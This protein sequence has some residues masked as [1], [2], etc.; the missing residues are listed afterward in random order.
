MTERCL[1]R[2][3]A[4]AT[5]L[6]LALLA[7]ACASATQPL[8][9]PSSAVS[10]ARVLIAPAGGSRGAQPQ[11]GIRVKVVDGT[12][13]GV[14]VLTSGDPVRGKLSR[15]G[16]TWR[17][18]WALDTAA[19]YTVVVKARDSAGRT[20]TQKSSFRTL[21][22][23][24]T[25]AAR[26]FE[27]EG[28]TYGVGMPIILDFSRP[29]ADRRVVERSLELRTSK[30][31]VGAWYWDGESTLSFRPRD[32]WPPGTRVSFVGHLDGVEGAPGV[33]GV[34]TLRQ[35]FV[36]G[37]SLIVVANTATHRVHVYRDKRL[38]G[39][40]PMS[41]GRPGDDTPNG[42]YLTIE[43]ANPQEMKGPGYDIM[44]PWSVRFTW[45]GDFLHDAS[46]SV[47]QQGYANV[48]HGCVN[49]SPEHAR[50]FYQLAVPGI[51]VTIAGSPRGGR[52]DNGWTLWFLSWRR[53]LQGSALHK[54]VRANA[55]GSRFVD[56]SSLRASRAKAPLARPGDGNAA[57]G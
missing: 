42:T 44:V 47:G 12:I 54:A 46:W 36:I 5:A 11:D 4:S 38:F 43:K 1:R 30:P 8:P 39:D 14:S 56:P 40:W 31:V 9:G 45:S 10:S 22:P 7:G 51:P 57:A 20:V 37:R 24:Q 33:Y 21:T 48:S 2:L 41:S 29:I 13:T 52:W 3:A 18:T 35:S 16:T 32:Y 55:G 27:A 6:A 53:L 34:H 23:K 26:I 25:F 19:A 17:S 15:D 50:T 28:A 49:L